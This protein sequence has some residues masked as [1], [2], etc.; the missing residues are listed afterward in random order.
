M[1][2]GAPVPVVVKGKEAA[3]LCMEDLQAAADANLPEIARDFYNS[4]STYQ[5]TIAE[6]SSAFGKYRL[7]SRVL[8]DVSKLDTS[9]TCLG[10]NIK[11]PLSI[12][13]AGLQAMAHPDGELATS[14]ACSTTGVNMAISSFANHPIEDIMAGGQRNVNYAMQLYTMKDRALQE[15]IIQKAEG[16]GCKAIFL[17][18]D[19]PV[20]G[21]R[22]NE[23]RNDFRTPEGLEFP[24]LELTTQ[25]IRTQ[26]HDSGFTAFNDDS[27]NWE[28]DIAWLRSKTKMQIWIKGILTAED[29]IL[30]I[31]YGCD[32][33]IV[34]NHGGRQL[35]GVPATIDALVECVDAAKGRIPIHVD[36]G[37]RKGTDIFIALALG[38][39]CVWVG[40][41]AIWGLAY[42][43]QAGVEKMITMLHEDFRRCMALCGCNTVEDI[44]RSCLAMMG[45]DGVLRRL[46]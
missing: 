10:R 16:A 20:L 27:H 32:G 33:I 38:A 7:R 12:S 30:A 5:T 14:R 40:R 18:A 45:I 21:V 19:S 41:P 15:R 2:G 8:V 25:K 31:K 26:T 6:N 42:K 13:P 35:D 9:T 39:K 36:G 23:W 4:G 22:F 29:T 3:I 1:S 37:F 44:K 28:R 34:S 43:G 11:F 46:E 17:T 24:T